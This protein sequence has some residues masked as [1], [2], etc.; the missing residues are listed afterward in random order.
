LLLIGI[1]AFGLLAAAEFTYACTVPIDISGSSTG[2]LLPPPI[3]EFKEQDFIAY[4]THMLLGRALEGARCNPVAVGF[5]VVKAGAHANTPA[6]VDAAGAILTLSR[7]RADDPQR[8]D[9]EV[10]AMLGGAYA[11]PQQEEVTRLAGTDCRL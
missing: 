2:G 4:P 11:R 7:R 9:E 3:H 5:Q 10:C 1:V 8:F 6:E